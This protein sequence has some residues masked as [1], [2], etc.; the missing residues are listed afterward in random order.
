MGRAENLA[1]EGC[2]NKFHAVGC[3]EDIGR[4][5]GGGRP[6]GDGKPLFLGATVVVRSAAEKD[7]DTAGGDRRRVVGTEIIPNR[8]EG[9]IGRGGRREHGGCGSGREREALSLVKTL[10]RA[11]VFGS[12]KAHNLR[13]SADGA[14]ID[15][16]GAA[17]VHLVPFS[18]AGGEFGFDG[19]VVG[20]DDDENGVVRRPGGGVLF[21][22]K[23]EREGDHESRQEEDGEGFFHST[24]T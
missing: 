8:E 7:I 21:W 24:I 20:G 18:E 5:V 12:Q 15:S 1:G 10:H 9:R 14:P 22:F 3:E 19:L 6:R 11:D 4:D 23:E 13:C 2:G 16:C 17:E